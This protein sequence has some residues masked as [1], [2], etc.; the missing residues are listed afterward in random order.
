MR[1]VHIWLLLLLVPGALFASP[2]Q[3]PGQ[4]PLAFTHVTVI[5]TTG[6]PEQTDMTVVVTGERITAVNKSGKTAVPKNAQV[7]ESRGKF[8]IPGLWDM[9]VHLMGKKDVLFPLF[10]ANGVTG[11]RDMGIPWEQLTQVQQW[12]KEIAARTLVGPR[13][14]TPGP[15]LTGPR[16]PRTVWP[17]SIPISDAQS[18][19]EAVDRL[20][21]AGVDFI[22]VH[23]AVPRDAY[24]AV[25]EEAN[26]RK[27]PFVGHV[28]DY[29][30]AAEASAAHQKS[31]EHLTGILVACS[32]SQQELRQKLTDVMPTADLLTTYRSRRRIEAESL[33]TFSE[34][35]AAALFRLFSKNGTWQVP[36]L[37]NLRQSAFPDRE[38]P[39][40]EMLSRYVPQPLR[41]RTRDIKTAILKQLT[42]EDFAIGIPLFNKQLEVVTAMK[43]AGVQLLAG[44]D[45][46]LYPGFSLHEEL[47]L[48]VRAGLTPME[49]LQA[50]TRSPAEYFGMLESLGT[51]QKGK[52]A[53]LVLLNA[54]PL[55]DI[56]NTRKI[57]AV[58]VS[59]T[60]VTQPDIKTMLAR[61]EAAAAQ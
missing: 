2:E 8:L 9:H 20:L 10:I 54:D 31:I 36:T 21:N 16:P 48:L 35:K 52:L 13:V 17:G 29:I 18:A 47:R 59:G 24:F 4:P 61:A 55:Q 40:E 58:V 5:D 11:V 14:L 51:V 3:W 25:S 44:T 50:A 41:E 57:E 7:I 12:R 46:V 43:Q 1:K 6:G 15:I 32:T 37:V 28:P 30:T 38:Y 49:A 42:P 19:R 45:M 22:K 39:E 23:N 33:A 53:D 26:K 56:S 60:I 27:V 34:D